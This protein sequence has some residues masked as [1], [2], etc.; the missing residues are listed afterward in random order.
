MVSPG[1][2]GEFQHR[3][4]NI[5]MTSPELCTHRRPARHIAGK[6][7]PAVDNELR[8]STGSLSGVDDSQ[9]IIAGFMGNAN[10]EASD[11]GHELGLLDGSRGQKTSKDQEINLGQLGESQLAVTGWGA[12]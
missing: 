9:Q 2:N 7:P 5:W 8:K 10:G 3:F 11:Q 1:T 4:R 12:I 6:A